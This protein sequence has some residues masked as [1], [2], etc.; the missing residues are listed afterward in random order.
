MGD[1]KSIPE[2]IDKRLKRRLLARGEISATA[3]TNYLKDLPDLSGN[4]DFVNFSGEV[5]DGGGESA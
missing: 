2:F 4:V 5:E 1:K 3:M